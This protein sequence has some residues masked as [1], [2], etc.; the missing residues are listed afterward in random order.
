MK[1][2]N[3]DVVIIGAGIIGLAFAYRL[4][5]DQP[6]TSIVILEK[7]TSIGKHASGRNSGVL[8]SG[9]YYKKG[10][11]KAQLCAKGAKQLNQFC[12][13]H[14]LECRKIG[15]VIVPM[16]VSDDQGVDTLYERGKA[17]GVNV[18]I[19]DEQRLKKLEPEARTASGRAL[20]LPDT[21]VVNPKAVIQTLLAHL[22]KQGVTVL[23]DTS[24]D[25]IDAEKNSVTT[26]HGKMCYQQLINSAGAYADR[27]AK[28][29]GLKHDYLMMPF[30]GVYFKVVG[31]I[32]KQLHHLIY[33]VPNLE[34]P[35]LGVHTTTSVDGSVYLGPTA[36][37]SFGREN[38]DG[39]TNLNFSDTAET[40][41]HIAGMYCRNTQ[42]VR[43][44]MH[45]ESQTLLF[46]KHLLARMQKL[47][48]NLRLENIQACTKRGIRPQLFDKTK[49]ALVM[50]FVVE[51]QGNTIHVLNAISP[52]FTSSFA[53]VEHVLSSTKERECEFS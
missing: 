17:N 51:K 8:H 5:Q 26:N 42:G 15:K 50:D 48:P 10:T 2:V 47:V 24:I 40:F 34:M 20:H 52:A 46:K 44:H 53:F 28:S 25:N 16:E 27:V 33:H 3:T 39:I 11:L 49:K 22:E 45:Y 13:S 12:Q 1:Q 36:M 32:A 7:E 31:D 21:S 41:K 30:R 14:Q 18:E 43:Q 23:Y 29:A 9:I 38:Y 37:P 35:F 4:K 6:Q 19:I